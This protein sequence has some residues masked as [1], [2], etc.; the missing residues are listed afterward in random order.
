MP[1]K[2]HQQ[3]KKQLCL[4]KAMRK[5]FPIPKGFTQETKRT[6]A[7]G[8]AASGRDAMLG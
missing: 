3:N 8:G 6:Q 4:A 7:P 1:F 2:Q 5:W